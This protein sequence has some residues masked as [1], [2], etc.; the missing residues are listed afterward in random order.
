MNFSL[1]LILYAKINSKWMTELN[2]KFK[3]IQLLEKNKGENLTSRA[4][5]RVPRLDTVKNNSLKKIPV[6]LSWLIGNEPN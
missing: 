1:N 6:L 5:Q 4:R 2:I 3:T